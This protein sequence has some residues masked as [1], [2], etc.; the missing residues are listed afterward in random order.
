M[1]QPKVS[2]F[3]TRCFIWVNYI[4]INQLSQPILFYFIFRYYTTP[5]SHLILSYTK[6]NSIFLRFFRKLVHSFVAIESLTFFMN[7]KFH[8]YCPRELSVFGQK[9]FLLETGSYQNNI[10]DINQI[11]S[12][13]FSILLFSWGS[14]QK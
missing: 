13:Y 7:A 11:D 10:S 12:S 8:F 5:S 1:V 2:P 3:S 6:N 9:I 4:V 14:H